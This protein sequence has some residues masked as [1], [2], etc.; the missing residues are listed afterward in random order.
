MGSKD[1]VELE[2]EL[3]LDA[4]LDLDGLKKIYDNIH[5]VNLG[6]AKRLKEIAKNDASINALVILDLYSQSMPDIIEE[7]LDEINHL[8]APFLS[9]E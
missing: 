7:K 6:I 4:D 5:K 3:D 9:K 2:D 1:K 8:F